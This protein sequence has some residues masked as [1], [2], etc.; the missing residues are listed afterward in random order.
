MEGNISWSVASSNSTSLSFFF[1]NAVTR[2][3]DQVIPGEIV[4]ENDVSISTVVGNW[5]EIEE[6]RN[7][8]NDA[9]IDDEE[10]IE[11]TGRKTFKENVTINAL[12]VNEMNVPV[13][14]DVNVI[15]FNNSVVRRDQD[16]TISEPISFLEE[17]GINEMLVNDSVHDVPLEGVVLATDKLPPKV[18]FKHLVVLRDV[19]LKNLDGIDFDKFVEERVTT[20]GDHNIDGDVQFDGVVEVTGSTSI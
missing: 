7:I 19:Y 3:T 20:N 17:V 1:K 13:I 4:F 2:T 15:E 8:V 10:V 9:V 6:I 5:K 16:E 18:T 14:N 12:S 11:V